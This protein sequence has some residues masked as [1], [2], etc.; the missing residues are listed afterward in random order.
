M[1]Y[2]VI[3]NAKKSIVVAKDYVA[4]IGAATTIDIKG[5]YIPNV[6]IG[7][8]IKGGVN[9]IVIFFQIALV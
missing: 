9:I 8:I 6:V 3:T 5:V 4:L 2:E 7:V 1:L